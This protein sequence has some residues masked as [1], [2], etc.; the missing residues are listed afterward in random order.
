MIA[1]LLRVPSA[2]LARLPR[3]SVPVL[4]WSALAIG[5][6]IV[7]RNGADHVLR[8]TFGFVALPLL[9]YAL[10][11]AALGPSGAL[12]GSL[13]GSVALGGA[14]RSA[15]FAT[16][17]FSVVASAVAAAVVGALVCAL[18]HGETDPPLASDLPATAGIACLA[19]AA[20]GAYFCAGAAIGKGT[21]RSVFLA[22]DWFIGARGGLGSVFT[23]R[24]HLA[25][26]LGGPLAFELPRKTSSLLLLLLVAIYGATAIALARRPVL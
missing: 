2:R 13:R 12:R 25:S 23:P 18:A 22:I 14:P 10:V 11:G 5:A 4:A 20:Y 24:G 15:A 17:L 6:A 1:A 7:S 3:S 19:G 8:S 9:V 16:V 26:L 21:M